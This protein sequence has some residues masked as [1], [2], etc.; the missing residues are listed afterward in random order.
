V[1]VAIWESAL[2]VG[3]LA[4]LPTTDPKSSWSERFFKKRF[5]LIEP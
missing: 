2:A 4:A 5:N 3:K 1:E